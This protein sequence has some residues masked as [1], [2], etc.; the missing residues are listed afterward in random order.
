MALSPDA[1][2]EK[3]QLENQIE[4]YKKR[5]EAA[6]T[7]ISDLLNNNRELEQRIDGIL[8]E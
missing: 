6:Q 8:F 3:Q 5:L 1:Q 7:K 2:R 4:E